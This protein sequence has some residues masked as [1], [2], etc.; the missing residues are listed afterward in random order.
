M[1]QAYAH[2]L[3]FEPSSWRLRGGP[4]AYPTYPAAYH[5]A[6][7]QPAFQD[8]N[9]VVS[10]STLDQTWRNFAE[11]E[12]TQAQGRFTMPRIGNEAMQSIT[13]FDSESRK[14]DLNL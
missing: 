2:S 8:L 6:N 11:V 13:E 4:S 14:C 12:A 3:R 5:S 9:H 1:D 7:S 10:R